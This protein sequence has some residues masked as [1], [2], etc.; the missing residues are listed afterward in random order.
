MWRR[1]VILC[2]IA[3]LVLVVLVG[4]SLTQNE[5]SQIQKISQLEEELVRE[6]ERSEAWRK[7]AGGYIEKCVR[8]ETKVERLEDELRQRNESRLGGSSSRGI[9]RFPVEEDEQIRRINIY[10]TDSPLASLGWIFVASAKEAGIDPRLSPAIACVESH[11]GRKIPAEC[12]AWGM[13]AGCVPDAQSRGGWQAFSSWE[14]GIRGH[15]AFIAR[16]WG[17]VTSPYQM[18]GYAEDPNWAGKVAREMRKI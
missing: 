17:Q 7:V 14:E 3:L 16:R 15:C 18:R 10:L 5:Q 6:K 4:R 2:L 8:F 12:N 13:K 1:I 9:A 11:L